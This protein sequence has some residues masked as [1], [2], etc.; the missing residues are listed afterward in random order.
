MSHKVY[1]VKEHK[2]SPT[3]SAAD[4]GFAKLYFKNDGLLY[5]MVGA[6]ET[7]IGWSWGWTVPAN[8]VVGPLTTTAGNV[9]YWSAT[10]NQLEDGYPVVTVIGTPGL[11]TNLVT[12]KAVRDA[13]SAG[14]LG[15]VIGPA[16]SLDNEVA[17]YSGTTWKLIKNSG[18]LA[19][20]GE[21]VWDTDTQTLTNKTIDVDNNTVSNIELDNFKASAITDDLNTSALAT[22][23][24]TAEEVKDYVDTEIA[25]WTVTPDSTTTLINKTIDADSNTI[26][27]INYNEMDPSFIDGD[28]TTVTPNTLASAEA[29]KNY[30]DFKITPRTYDAIVS[31]DVAEW[32][33]TTIGAAIAGG[34]RTIYV[35]A[36]HYTETINNTITSD[37]LITGELK[38][39]V[40]DIDSSDFIDITWTAAVHISNMYFNFG[41]TVDR[42]ININNDQWIAILDWIII[43]SVNSNCRAINMATAWYAV[44]SN[45]LLRG[46]FS[47]ELLW[48]G[49][50]EENP[51]YIENCYFYEW[52]HKLRYCHVT[53]SRFEAAAD[54]E[55][56][57]SSL[58]NCAWTLSGPTSIFNIISWSRLVISWYT[59]FT[60]ESFVNNYTLD[61][62]VS[63]LRVRDV[64]DWNNIDCSDS[65]DFAT[66]CVISDNR[67]SA[68]IWG[69]YLIGASNIFT[70]NNVLTDQ[71]DFVDGNESVITWNRFTVG[72]DLAWAESCTVTGNHVTGDLVGFWTRC[73]VSSN[74][75]TG[76]L[77]GNNA[78]YCSFVWNVA[79]PAYNMSWTGSQSSA[80]VDV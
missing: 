38:W 14:G 18:K 25:A 51:L 39:V 32:D 28:L 7:V 56:S 34:A 78:T 11:D 76:W 41:A 52:L 17:L 60:V 36:G 75:V 47:N 15:D 71:I 80:N 24:A 40:V 5:K 57:Y 45:S 20:S 53:W 6:V 19:P 16:S 55:G 66:W 44:I 30:V 67:L 54:I 37:L 31:D 48:S 42:F 46:V 65:I 43:G 73:V 63:G 2:F 4:T 10:T 58:F 8:N 3:P 77:N 72:L 64:C 26:T 61:L 9:P 29:I 68:S 23:F 35:K 1:A 22:Q 74:R 49:A 21:F 79:D 59:A 12:E 62:Q 27:N 50:N 69:D 33:Y 13:M 70:G